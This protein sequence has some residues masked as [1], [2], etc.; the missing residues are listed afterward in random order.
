MSM[1]ILLR[2]LPSSLRASALSTQLP[3]PLPVYQNI[4]F[5]YRRSFSVTMPPKGEKDNSKHNNKNGHEHVAKEHSGA[6]DESHQFQSGARTDRK[7]DEWKHRAPYKI[8][9]DDEKFD[10]KWKGGCHCGK[11]KYELSRDKPLATKFCHCSTCQKL[12]GV[13]I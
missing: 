9:G 11:V 13:S 7:E 8:H 3:K 12:H 1:N 4:A 10:T 5:C 2:R 6:A